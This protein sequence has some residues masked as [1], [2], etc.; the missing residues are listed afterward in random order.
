[1]VTLRTLALVVLGLI[2]ATPALHAQDQSR[3]RG[4]QLGSDARSVS[5]LA[6]VAPSDVK[7]I[8]QRPA[9]MQE[10]QWR[11]SSF[12]SGSTAPQTDPV[13]RIVFSFYNDQLSKIVVD[14]DHD[15][16]AGLTDADMID[17]MSTEYG[18]PLKPAVKKTRAVTSQVELESGTP[19]A[20]WGNAD[21]SVVLYRASYMSG[22]RI[23]VTSSRLEALAQTADA[24]AI[25]LDATEAPQREIARQKKE[26]EDTRA[27]QEKARLSNKAAFRP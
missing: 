23:I 10:L 15:R 26:A 14:Y 5:A 8:H 19:I 3:Y 1:M 27:S 12:V 22:F 6:Q 7:T 24:E 4:F 16:T 17:A 11:I 2:L 13:Q 21:S 25:R 18:P 20:R 9:V